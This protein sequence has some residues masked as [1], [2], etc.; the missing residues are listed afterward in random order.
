[1]AQQTAPFV[2]FFDHEM[3]R[4]LREMHKLGGIGDSIHLF[5]FTSNAMEHKGKV[6]YLGERTRKRKRGLFGRSLPLEQR[7]V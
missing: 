3:L 1:M 7:K 2:L 4:K 6:R 5:V